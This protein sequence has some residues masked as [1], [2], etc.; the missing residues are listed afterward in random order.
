MERLGFRRDPEGDFAH[1]QLPAE[2]PLSLH[3][4]YR[5]RLDEDGRAC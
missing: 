4:L 1:P 5:A 3:W 2:H